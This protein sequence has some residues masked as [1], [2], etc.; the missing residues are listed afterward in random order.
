M[1]RPAPLR[2]RAPLA[3]ASRAAGTWTREPNTEVRQGDPPKSEA[4]QRLLI[5]SEQEV[6]DVPVEWEPHSHRR[7]LLVWGRHG[8]MSIRLDSRVLSIP[9]GHGLWLPGGTVHSGRLTARM[10]FH[11]A[12]FDP[13]RTPELFPGPTVVA[14]TPVLEALLNHLARTDLEEAARAR[15]ERVVFDVM[16]ADERP[17]SVELPEDH[18][19]Q[20]IVEAL[21]KDPGDERS[22]PDW[23]QLAGVSERTVT[24]AFQETTGLSFARWRQSLRIQRALTLLDAGEEIQ[25]ISDVLG[26]S[27]PSTFIAAFRRLMGTTPGAYRDRRQDDPRH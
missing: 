1:S 17:L 14:M 21:L 9:E 27:Q 24:R 23:A 4:A 5:L 19:L 13:E 8:S 20:P 16:E 3:A 12:F 2:R 15:A 25:D 7:H 18:R 10:R 22:L 6:P 26:Y 11:D